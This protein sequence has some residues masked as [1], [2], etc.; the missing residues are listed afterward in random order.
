MSHPV[1]EAACGLLG[2]GP[3]ARLLPRRAQAPAVRATLEVAVAPEALQVGAERGGR[4]GEE[5]GE[6]VSGRRLRQSLRAHPV[7]GLEQLVPNPQRLELAHASGGEPLPPF[8]AKRSAIFSIAAIEGIE[9][10]K[11]SGARLSRSALVMPSSKGTTPTTSSP[12][13][14]ANSSTAARSCSSRTLLATSTT[15]SSPRSLASAA[16]RRP[17]SSDL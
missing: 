11:S 17:V 8:S 12:C 1:L 3:L 5:A 10:S 4:D 16:M 15:R 13:F 6:L 7:H 9:G 2:E 14:S